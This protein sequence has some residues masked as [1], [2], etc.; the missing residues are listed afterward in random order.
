[1]SCLRELMISDYKGCEFCGKP[2]SIKDFY[3][4]N[5]KLSL[6]ELV[7]LWNNTFY[8]L[9]CCECFQNTSDNFWIKIKH[10]K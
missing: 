10:S 5:K 8:G 9:L 7:S 4:S 3:Y 2:L 1:M 6:Q